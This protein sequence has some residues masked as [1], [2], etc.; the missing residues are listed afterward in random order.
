MTQIRSEV[1]R[2]EHLLTSL[3]GY[4]PHIFRP[5]YGFANK[6]DIKELGRL[7]YKVID[8]SVDT[9]DWAGTPPDRIMEYVHKEATPGAIVLEHCAG[10]RHEKLDNTI[11]ALPRIIS[12]FK[13]RGY[14]FVTIPELLHIHR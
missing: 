9:R 4:K 6:N 12:Y 11:E 2:T 10:G 8:W 7:G 3:I 1:D 14:R 13:E 5:P